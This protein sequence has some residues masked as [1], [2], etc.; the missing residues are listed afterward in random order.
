MAGLN[1][2]PRSVLTHALV[3]FLSV[4]SLLSLAASN[5]RIRGEM[6]QEHVWAV[7]SSRDH[8]F[9][10]QGQQMSCIGVQLLAIR[11]ALSE[12]V[13]LQITASAAAHRPTAAK[14]AE[15]NAA[16]RSRLLSDV[17]SRW[18]AV[19]NLVKE[20]DYSY[21]DRGPRCIMIRFNWLCRRLSILLSPTHVQRLEL[22][23]CVPTLAKPCISNSASA[24]SQ[25]AERRSC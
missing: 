2:I 20:L 19:Q 25:Q 13:K 1:R 16:S 14:D 4:D 21:G 23:P 3:P 18:S 5:K 11:H 10:P 22:S 7:L 17:L 6:Q 15:D 8:L 12:L 9:V 24:R